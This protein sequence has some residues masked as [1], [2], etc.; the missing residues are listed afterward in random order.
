MRVVHYTISKFKL[1]PPEMPYFQGFFELCLSPKV[2]SGVAV[3][4][5]IVT[6]QTGIFKTIPVLITV[7]VRLFRDMISGYFAPAPRN[8][9]AIPHRVSLA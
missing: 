4:D 8:F 6:D 3:S 7:E 1:Q 9:F 5:R 2:G